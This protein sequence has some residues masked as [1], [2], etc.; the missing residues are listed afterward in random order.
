[1]AIILTFAIVF[2]NMWDEHRYLSLIR[3]SERI[4]LQSQA[5][6]HFMYLL[7]KI[8][9]TRRQ[10]HHTSY[11]KFPSK[12]SFFL[13]YQ[14]VRLLSSLCRRLSITKMGDAH[15]NCDFG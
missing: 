10:N 1:M 9:N 14:T 3:L 13:S 5:R 8:L 6:V 12:R 4:K 2:L 11:K 7:L 15:G